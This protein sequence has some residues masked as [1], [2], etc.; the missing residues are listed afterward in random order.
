[1]RDLFEIVTRATGQTAATLLYPILES[2]GCLQL[3]KLL[4]PIPGLR[5]SEN[6]PLKKRKREMDTMALMR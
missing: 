2:R 1:M 6:R 5:T 4:L 3:L